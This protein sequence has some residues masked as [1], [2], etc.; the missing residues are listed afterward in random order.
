LPAGKA[1]GRGVRSGI[2]NP[3]HVN[4]LFLKG[5]PISVQVLQRKGVLIAGTNGVDLDMTLQHLKSHPRFLYDPSDSPHPIRIG[6][7]L[8]LAFS[9]KKRRY[10]DANR[11]GNLNKRPHGGIS[12]APLQVSQIAAL[13][14]G[15]LGKLLLGPALRS[16]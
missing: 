9:T 3:Q 8:L 2:K 15:A 12:I 7:I 1:H 4:S 5:H 6:I 10:G 16:P 13:N 14:G 11:I